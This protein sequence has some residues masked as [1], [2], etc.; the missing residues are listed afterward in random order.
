M[1]CPKC[2][3]ENP[4]DAQLCRACG[5]E[6]TP[7]PSPPTAEDIVPRRSG[8]AIAALV[9][10]ILSIFTCG[11]TAIPAIALGI[12][13]L[14]SIEKSGGALTGRVFAALGVVIP[15]LVFFGLFVLLMPA[16]QRVK[17]QAQAVACRSRLKQ[18]GLFFAMYTSDNDGYFP[19][20]TSD[21]HPGYWMD[22]LRGYYAND[23]DLRCCPTATEPVID[24][25]G[26]PTA[27]RSVFS[28]WGI[29]IG[30]GSAP[31]GDWGSYGINGWV[32]RPTP[33]QDMVYGRFE[34]ANHWGT[35]NVPGAGSIP[36]FMDALHFRVF[37]RHTDNPPDT[38]DMAWESIQQMQRVCINRHDGFGN[39]LFMDWSVRKVGLKE[40]WTL[41]WHRAYN[42]EGP[43]TKAGH[44]Q[45]DD[46]PPWM[47]NFRDY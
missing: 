44:V 2:G 40:L 11:L 30:E 13:G 17:K 34:A 47:K 31:E 46:W 33:Q 24:E 14:V 7:S 16:L 6:L 21:G 19:A 27:R 25:Y 4:D 38:Q 12:I 5:A 45:S 18:W 8:L 39:S 10:G 42:T 20:A 36:V 22:A 1:Y 35:P 15:V 26:Q 28:A 32:Q 37:P 9:L 29:F 41:K 23:R 3:T 43:W